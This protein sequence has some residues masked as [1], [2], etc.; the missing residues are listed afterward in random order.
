MKRFLIMLVIALLAGYFVA[1]SLKRNFTT[2]NTDAVWCE[3]PDTGKQMPPSLG[4]DC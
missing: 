3:D 4:D 2:A 1:Q